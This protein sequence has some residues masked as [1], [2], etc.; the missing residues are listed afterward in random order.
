MK[1]N[2]N[3]DSVVDHVCYEFSVLMMFYSLIEMMSLS[4]MILGGKLM[5]AALHNDSSVVRLHISLVCVTKHNK[6]SFFL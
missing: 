5:E 2:P 4:G 3:P 6:H 1:V